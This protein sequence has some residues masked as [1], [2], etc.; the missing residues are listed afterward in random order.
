[1][2]TFEITVSAIAYFLRNGTMHN[3]LTLLHILLIP[4]I[5]SCVLHL[6][7]QIVNLHIIIMLRWKKANITLY[8]KA[9]KRMMKANKYIIQYLG[10]TQNNFIYSVSMFHV[11]IF[12]L[13]LSVLCAR[14]RTQIVF[15][16]H[17][18]SFG[19]LFFFIATA[20]PLII[21]HV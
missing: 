8:E 21:F 6:I 9:K 20:L 1:M 5:A 15:P 10:A 19:Y 14:I 3:V 18:T 11:N 13:Y 4:W 2:K 16:F 17:F 12:I 7:N